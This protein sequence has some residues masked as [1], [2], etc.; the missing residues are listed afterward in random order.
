M[1][2]SIKKN[3]I[4]NLIYTGS[5]LFFPLITFPYICRVIGVEGVG[6]VNFFNSIIGY[7]A[8]FTCLGI[9][10]YAIREIARLRDD[11]KT[12]TKTTV[13]ILLLYSF[14]TLIGY[15]VVAILCVFIPEIHNDVPLFLVLSLTIFF[16][17]IGCEWFYQGIEDFTYITVRGLIVKVVSLVLLFVFVRSENDLLAYGVYCVIGSVGSNVFNFIRLRKYIKKDNIVFSNLNVFRHLKPAIS[18]FFFSLTVSFYVR[19]NPVLLGFM[20]DDIAVG[21]YSAAIK[22]LTILVSLSACLGNV[23]MPRLSNLVENNSKDEFNRLIQKSY[24]LTL[25]LTIPLTFGLILTAP[26]IIMLLCGGE[27]AESI[28]SSQIIAP[29]ILVVGVSNVIGIQFLYPKGKLSLVTLCCGIGAL[30]DVILCICLIPSF[31][32]LGASI[33]YLSAEMFTTISMIYFTRKELSLIFFNWSHLKYLI[34][35][36]LMSIVVILL[37]KFLLINEWY[38]FGLQIVLGGIVYFLFLLVTKDEIV[39]SIYS[40]LLKFRL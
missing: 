32:F 26:Y 7:I 20:K 1:A 33:A 37:Q 14:L 17:A 40:S 3:F 31:S 38:S 30:F 12:V 9:P 19:L 27:F 23:M 25:L 13:E 2:K 21:L 11:I 24:D 6:H 5:S 8:M 35:A 36:I 4:L 29:I 22:V 18:V 34:G 16:S 39:Y 10:M 15:I 28:I